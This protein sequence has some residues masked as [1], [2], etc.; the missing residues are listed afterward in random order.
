MSYEVVVS[1]SWNKDFRGVKGKY[2]SSNVS[3]KYPYY[4]YNV[5]AKDEITTLD[6]V[7]SWVRDI[8]GCSIQFSNRT[9]KTLITHY[10]VLKK[11][12]IT[13]FRELWYSAF[14]YESYGYDKES[15]NFKFANPD[16][17]KAYQKKLDYKDK[18]ETEIALAI[19]ND[20]FK[21][22]IR[23]LRKEKYVLTN[24]GIFIVKLNKR[25]YRYTNE[26]NRHV[27]VF[28]GLEV[29]TTHHALR[30][31][32]F[33]K[34]SELEKWLVDRYEKTNYERIK[35]EYGKEHYKKWLGHFLQNIK[36]ENM[37]VL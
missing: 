31:F 28:N 26:L 6:Y 7:K 16:D 14:D 1:F 36:I 27:K 34:V 11:Y 9:H 24:G 13:S 8:I 33:V 18:I 17:E 20:S 2:Y 12:G 23:E 4:D 22:E 29:I 35:K 25:G 30:E 15:G 19:I 10:L 37:G 21:R 32:E 5:K 3:P